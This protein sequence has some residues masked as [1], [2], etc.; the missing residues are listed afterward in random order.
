MPAAMTSNAPGAAQIVPDS[1]HRGLMAILPPPARLC[2]AGPAGP[3]DRLVA[4]V[5]ALRLGRAAG[6]RRAA[7]GPAGLAAAGQRGDARRGLRLQRHRGCGHRP[8]V[9]RTALRPIAS[10][11]VSRKAAWVWL[12]VLCLI[13]LVVLLQLH[14]Q[15][16]VALGSLALV[17]AYP[18]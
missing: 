4:A 16:Q 3:A 10:G 7:L 17:A 9:A 12:V 2:R 6:G 1:Q 14:W 13:G 5:L 8:Q 11:R 18:S 15:A